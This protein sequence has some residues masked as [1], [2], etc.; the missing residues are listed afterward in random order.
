[1]PTDWVATFADR[2]GLDDE[3]AQEALGAL[4][5]PEYP[6]IAEASSA[7]CVVCGWTATGGS[8]LCV[9][10]WDIHVWAA[11]NRAFNDLLYRRAVGPAAPI[12][13][14]IPTGAEL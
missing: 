2:P 8:R 3:R 1:M 9:G 13:V 4:V 10:C 14:V 6:Q 7:G 12:E 5:A 11:V